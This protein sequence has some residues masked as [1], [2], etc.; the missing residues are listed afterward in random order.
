MKKTFIVV[1]NCIYFFTFARQGEGWD[2]IN[3]FNPAAFM[4]LSEVGILAIVCLVCFHHFILYTRVVR[5][6]RGLQ[7]YLRDDKSLNQSTIILINFMFSV[8]SR[9]KI[10]KK[11]LPVK[12]QFTFKTI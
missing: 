3:R 4:R 7:A 10:K 9:K 8:L 1:I 6:V 5:K 12:S 11:S 2:P